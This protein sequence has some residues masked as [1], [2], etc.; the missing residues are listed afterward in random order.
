MHEQRKKSH[1]PNASW[2]ECISIC[3]VIYDDKEN[4]LC[5]VHFFFWTVI[6]AWGEP[7][8]E[9]MADSLTAPFITPL[10]PVVCGDMQKQYGIIAVFFCEAKIEL[11][12]RLWHQCHCLA[13]LF[14]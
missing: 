6:I 12:A 4:K 11:I 8:L 5:T 14:L 7:L 3:V 2:F 1:Y 9:L 10:N 13:V